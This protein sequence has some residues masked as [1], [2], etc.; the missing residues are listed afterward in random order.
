MSQE[1]HI[2]REDQGFNYKADKDRGEAEEGGG[3]IE[4]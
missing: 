4:D 3:A 1:D 2:H